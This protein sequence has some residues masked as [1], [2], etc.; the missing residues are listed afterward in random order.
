MDREISKQTLARE[1]KRRVV[2]LVLFAG[3]VVAVVFILLTIL[4]NG[5]RRDEL[6]FS[7]IDRGA[8]ELTINTSGIVQPA[9]EE[10]VV[11]PISSRLLQVFH[12][13]GDS[14]QQGTPLLQLDLLATQSSYEK[15]RDQ[16]QMRVLEGEQRE[17]EN[18]SELSNMQMRLKVMDMQIDQKRIELKNAL[19]LDSLGGGTAGTVRQVEM[20][21]KVSELEREQLQLKISNA[22]RIAR[23]QRNV[24]DLEVQIAQKNLAEIEKVLRD[25]RIEAPRTGILTFINTQVGSQISSG[26]Q[27][28]TVSDLS[29]FRIDGEFPDG[30]ASRVT[31]G[32]PVTIRIGGHHQNGQ[33]T[34]IAPAS[35][36]G[37]LGF[38]VQIIDS[39]VSGLRS[40]LKVELYLQTAKKQDVLRM[41]YASFYKKPGKYNLW[42]RDGEY[43]RRREVVLGEASYQYIEVVSGLRT[44]DEVVVSDL[45]QYKDETALRL[46]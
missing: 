29:Q 34:R 12:K 4:Q 35:K 37:T 46:R 20:T 24:K 25:A 18:A 15:L 14:V 13:Y 17:A 45:S 27:V 38:T 5:V 23:A 11:S 30:Y 10:A 7:T 39:V 3:V 42:V 9:V 31:T 43:I 36:N 40:G 41:G 16:L 21:L 2:K 6:Q 26:Q 1:R 44:G 8:I 33:V 28:A 32:T 19:R 22:Q